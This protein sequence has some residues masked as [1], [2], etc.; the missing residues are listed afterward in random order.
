MDNSKY[1]FVMDFLEKMGGSC[2]L[3]EVNHFSTQLLSEMELRGQICF[4]KE[5]GSF[6]VKIAPLGTE[7]RSTSVKIPIQRKEPE[8]SEKKVAPRVREKRRASSKKEDSTFK[9]PRQRTEKSSKSTTKNTEEGE[10]ERMSIDFIFSIIRDSGR[11]LTA[12]DIHSMMPERNIDAIRNHLRLLEKDGRIISNRK[13][14]KH[15][16][17]PDRASRISGYENIRVCRPTKISSV[18]SVLRS[19]ETE[20]NADEISERCSDSGSPVFVETVRNTLNYLLLTNDV[21]VYRENKSSSY[22]FA[23]PSNTVAVESLRERRES[24]RN[25]I[26]RYLEKT[27]TSYQSMISKNVI[28]NWRTPRRLIRA[29]SQMRNEGILS[30]RADRSSLV[31]SLKEKHNSN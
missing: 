18:L 26:I 2:L 5:N 16:V 24:L 20:L 4:Y 14:A 17:L 3:R 13:R 31:Y 21:V 27:G 6:A 1:V 8:A 12:R 28:G 19:A 22:Y 29:L 9:V 15:F 10:G 23:L 7:E 30:V 25:K 11:P